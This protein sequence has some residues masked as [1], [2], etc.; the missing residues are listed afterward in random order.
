MEHVSSRWLRWGD[1]ASV[2]LLLASSIFFTYRVL[3]H[4]STPGR[5]F[6]RVAYSEGDTVQLGPEVPLATAKLTAV[7]VLSP[8]CGFCRQSLPLYRELSAVARDSQGALR[9]VFVAAADEAA[10][11]QLLREGGLVGTNLVARPEGLRVAGVPMVLLTD[12]TGRVRGV[13]MGLLNAASKADL[14]DRARMA[15]RS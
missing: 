9:L 13:W 8:T 6:P 15:T 1:V 3:R 4:M 12:P 5:P 14:L 11:R 10:T 7:V 2:A